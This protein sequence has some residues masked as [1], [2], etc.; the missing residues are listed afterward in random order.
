MTTANQFGMKTPV[1]SDYIKD[2]DDAIS[3]N[4]TK[5]AELFTDL[6]D[7]VHGIA[8]PV[9][10]DLNSR[11]PTGLYLIR[12]A[13]L[14]ASLKNRPEGTGDT[15]AGF[16]VVR[17]LPNSLVYQELTVY[18]PAAAQYWRISRSLGDLFPAWKDSTPVPPANDA[19]PGVLA[20]VA[21]KVRLDEFTAHHGGTIYT[22]GRGAVALRFDHGLGNFRD[23]VLPLLRKHSLP[24]ALAL[25]SRNWDRAENGGVTQATVRDWVT[26]DRA[27]IWNH[28]ATH[29]NATTEED[30]RDEIVTGLAELKAQIPNANI[31]GWM[32]PGVGTPGYDGF[33]AGTTPEAF[34][35]T[36][37]GRLILEN[38]A[39]SS[40]YFPGTARRVL[41]GTIRQGQNH[42]TLDARTLADAKGQIDA[43]QKE[44][45][46]LQLMLHPSVMNADGNIT[47][48]VLGQIFAYIAAERDA[49]RLVVLSPYQMMLADSA[50][51]PRV[52]ETA[53]RVVTVWDQINKRDQ[54]IYGDTGER[55]VSSL[56]LDATGEVFLRRSG[57]AVTF[58]LSG[59]TPNADVGTYT[60]MN[61]PGG[62]RPSSASIKAWLAPDANGSAAQKSTFVYRA[63]RVLIYSAEKTNQYR[64][65]FTF[66]TDDPWPTTLPGTA[67]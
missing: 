38:H 57:T 65:T 53:G 51:L 47:T 29:G 11:L 5:S 36:V 49:G 63:G 67:V 15:N 59:V 34:Y 25:N 12:N 44:G 2:G 7:R 13:T 37:S 61:L 32:V 4:A 60:L 46:G 10:T 20:G 50:P 54:L 6:I 33:N 42:Y 45:T 39:V 41:D 66:H 58:T 55:D 21:N 62:F 48:A 16:L 35:N 18:Q 40:G 22:H 64:H 56:L 28:G 52:S 27:E 31:D 3:V 43:A 19:G 26:N 17:E 14:W 23:L 9:G 8:L 30:L 1:D 24:F